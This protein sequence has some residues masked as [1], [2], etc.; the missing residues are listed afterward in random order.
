MKHNVKCKSGEIGWQATLHEVYNDLV[1]FDYYDDIY[2]LAH[3][4]GFDNPQEAWDANPTI[5]GSTNPNDY[6]RVN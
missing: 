5:K 2:G 4:L 3:R 6:E 1:E